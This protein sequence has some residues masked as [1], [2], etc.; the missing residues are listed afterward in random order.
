MKTKAGSIVFACLLGLACSSRAPNVNQDGFAGGTV[1]LGGSSGTGGIASA[2]G[3]SFASSINPGGH[4][5]GTSSTATFSPGGTISTSSS[6][7]AT[8]SNGGQT[9]GASTSMSSGLAGG[10]S[11]GGQTTSYGGATVA[12]AAVDRAPAGGSGGSPTTGGVGSGGA[13]A[14]GGTRDA[15]QPS[16]ADADTPPAT[17]GGSGRSWQQ[18]QSDFIDLRFGMFICLGILTYT[19]SWGQPN[20]PINQFNPTNLDCNQWADAAVSAKMTF[21]V[22]TTRHHDGFALWPSKA[23]TFNVG[24]ITWRS[25]KGDV[26]QE[27]VTAF[28]A[29][30]L[31]PGL[32]Y[33]IWDSTQNNGSNG[34]LSA[35]QMQYIETQL[36]E[37][38]SNYGKIPLL[39]LDG[40]AWKMGH[41][42]APFAEIHDL[43][44]SLQPEILIVDHDGIQGPWDADLVMYEEPKGVF[45]PTGNT[46][47]AAQDNKING[48]GGND[49]FWAPDVGGLMT[50][51]AIVGG[52]LKK[53]EA[54]Y[55]NFILNCPPNRE[56][57]LDQA[58][59]DILTQVGSSWTPNAS[60]A[61]LPAQVP[62]NE[63]PY[64]PTGATATSGTASSAIDGVN[65][66]GVNTVWTS[67][68]SFPQSLTLD[69]GSVKPDVGYF[70]YLPGYAGNGPTTNGSITSYKILVSSDNSVYSPAT[71]G[72]WPGDG[73][74]QGVLFGPVAARYVRLEA[75]AVNGTGGA[76]ATEVV[77]GARR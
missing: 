74:Y 65:D 45:S 25:G 40:W 19:G 76:Q 29:K 72:T 73:K 34:A 69:L 1:V 39:V 13:L 26:V 51:S 11:S 30:G 24:N 10:T 66:V 43:I 38:L 16:S 31:Q 9:T 59:L 36:T 8:A 32:Y 48:T 5:G 62:L 6:P 42:N 2:G 71:S 14:T 49:W 56:G 64:M 41:R 7:G 17:D 53:L 12:D 4:I 77:V 20:L 47:A 63:H 28:R 60:R 70:G 50:A 52:H 57:L 3:T 46:I 21:G 15:G 18:I 22:L 27:Y 44:K 55:T 37:L 75:D 61:P 68:T 35:T 33:S 67:S 58:I 23:S 54:S